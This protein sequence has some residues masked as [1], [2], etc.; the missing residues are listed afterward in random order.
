MYNEEIKKE[1]INY[2]LSKSL[3]GNQESTNRK[4]NGILERLG[5]VESEFGIDISHADYETAMSMVGMFLKGGAAYQNS[6]L[7][8]VRQYLEWC[9]VNGKTPILENPLAGVT[10]KDIDLRFFYKI[11]MVKEERELL[12]YLDISLKPIQ[13]DTIDNLYR[14]YCLLLFSGLTPDEA[15][16]IKEV[17]VKLPHR[18]IM[19]NGNTINLSDKTT[20][21]VKTLMD[22][23]GYAKQTKS[24]MSIRKKANDEYLLTFSTENRKYVSLYCKQAISKSNALYRTSTG[25][26]TFLNSTNIFNSGIFNRMYEKE[27]QI[28]TVDLQEYLRHYTKESMSTSAFGFKKTTGFLEYD[29]WKRAFAL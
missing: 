11:S 13:A 24:G 26:K 22:M 17:D 8:E 18:R 25:K 27:R 14:V 3:S 16:H 29:T 12:E 19:A 9:I 1:F 28:G 7:S 21:F 20:Y 4:I 15:L 10:V 2:Y 23:D 5:R 6:Q